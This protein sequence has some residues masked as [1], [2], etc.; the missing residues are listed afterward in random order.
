MAHK[1]T[2]VIYIPGNHDE[3]FRDYVG[4]GFGGIE[5]AQEAIHEADDGRLLLVT[6]G[7]MFDSIVLYAKWFA[8]LGKRR[9]PCC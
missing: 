3:M 1:G 4:P 2:C 9:T 8:F 6:H 7:D 5:L